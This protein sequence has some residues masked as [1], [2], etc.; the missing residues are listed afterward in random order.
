[1]LDYAFTR[2]PCFLYAPDR[3]HYENDE[4]GFYFDF[5]TLPFPISTTVD[6]LI[7]SIEKFDEEKFVKKEEE[8]LRWL[9]DFED[10]RASERIALDIVDFIKNGKSKSEIINKGKDKQI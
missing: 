3:E 5:D 7:E 9:G 8:F 6:G 10:G 1:M 2:K 4:R